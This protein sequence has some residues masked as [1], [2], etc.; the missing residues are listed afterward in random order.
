MSKDL[1]N[2]RILSLPRFQ[3]QM[4]DWLDLNTSHPVYI[5]CEV[6]ITEARAT[7]RAARNHNRKPLSL[8]AYL[9]A[10]FA[11]AIAENKLVQAFRKGRAGIAI[12]D[13]VDLAI[14]VERELEG[15]KIPLPIIVRDCQRLTPW[16]IDEQIRRA[17]SEELPQAW[18]FRWLGPWLLLPSPARRFI[19]R[20]LLANP[21]RR[22]RMTGTAMVSAPG[23]FG[24]G[25]GWGVTPPS[26]TVFLLI[27]SITKK[28]M[29]IGDGIETREV[30]GLTICFDH[31]IV[32][33]AVGARFAQRLKEIIEDVRLLKDRQ[34]PAADSNDD[35]GLHLVPRTAAV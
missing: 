28:P 2:P 3:R 29:A 1:Q 27:G 7:I 23:M 10:C 4:I 22:K 30:L 8:N 15:F 26:Y 20:R 35:A 24:H 14:P 25:A 11:A 9:S 16:E 18:A 21:I 31:D 5:I 17:R 32:D 13:E 6:D 34:R 33:G 12:F 19:L